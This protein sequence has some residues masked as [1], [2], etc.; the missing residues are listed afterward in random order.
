MGPTRRR[1]LLAGAAAVAVIALW[2]AL[3][4]GAN[5]I[6]D[7]TMVDRGPLQATID[8]DGTTRSRDRYVVASPVTG[9]LSRTHF[10]E[11]DVVSP[12]DTLASVAPPPVDP[13]IA[14]TLRAEIQA[15]EAR[16]LEA[17][18]AVTDA[19]ARH[20]QALR[21]SERR[22]P[23]LELGAIS[24]EALERYEASE[25][26]ARLALARSEAVLDAATAAVDAANAR[27]LGTASGGTGAAEPVT[28]PVPG[29]VLRVFE[30]S[31]RVVSAGSPLFEISGPGGLEIVADILTEEAVSV[32]PGQPVLITGWGGA[33]A[34][35]GSVRMVEPAAFT[36]VSA[37]GVEEQRVNVVVD[38][39]DPPAGLGAGY[40]VDVSVVTWSEDDV[41]T[42]PTSAVFSRGEG[43]ATFVV[44]G[45]RARIRDLE[46]GRRGSESVQ[47]L[48]GL[49]EGEQVIEYPPDD[50]DDGVRVTTGSG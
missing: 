39:T 9:R 40:R 32:R 12:G 44:E 42:V 33:D 31:E 38:I 13:G 19:E 49:E 6:V 1:A 7:V 11:G 23:L 50:V 36:R 37:L 41:L 3:G 26:A 34:L 15:A 17:E 22:G 4:T 8:E 35:M 16:R 30:E 10:D 20:A 29:V 21:E 18:R 45:G 24:R 47:V 14:A 2:L 46:I 43:W 48:A 5:V 25:E 28:S 27:L